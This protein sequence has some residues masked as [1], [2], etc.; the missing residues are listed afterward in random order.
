MKTNL[1]LRSACHVD[2]QR[3]YV[4]IRRWLR[5]HTHAAWQALQSAAAAVC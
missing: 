4:A 3:L 1:R 5:S 2:E